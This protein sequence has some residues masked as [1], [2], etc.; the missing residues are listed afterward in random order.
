MLAQIN[1]AST[2]TIDK[3]YQVRTK[4]GVNGVIC[5]NWLSSKEL[6]E[7]CRERSGE[8]VTYKLEEVQGNE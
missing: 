3:R 5:P 8:V 7:Y 4:G 1:N 6:D 2:V